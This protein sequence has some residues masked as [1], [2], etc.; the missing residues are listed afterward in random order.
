MAEANVIERQSLVDV[1]MMRCGSADA[2]YDI[3]LLNDIPLTA[4]VNPGTKLLLPP[5]V[6]K[7]VVS[8]YASKGYAPA[9]AP[10]VIEDA[11][12]GVGYWYISVDFIVS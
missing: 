1:A 11:L 3:A 6:N 8:L 9:T 2:A 10:D 12:E 5:V 4:I 7:S